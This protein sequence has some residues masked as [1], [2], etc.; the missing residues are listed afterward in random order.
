M[1]KSFTW[2]DV[3]LKTIA[4]GFKGDASGDVYAKDVNM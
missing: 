1:I 3:A 2:C 4:L